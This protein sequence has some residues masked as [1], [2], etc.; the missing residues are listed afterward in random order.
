MEEWRLSETQRAAQTQLTMTQ[1]ANTA[2]LSTQGQMAHI[3]TDG[4]NR[5]I[6]ILYG[7]FSGGAVILLGY[8]L[9]HLH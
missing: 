1:Q 2:Q 8:I 9:T 6:T 4:D 3:R 5:L 7:L